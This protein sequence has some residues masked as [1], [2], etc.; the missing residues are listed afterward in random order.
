MAKVRVKIPKVV[1]RIAICT[2]LLVW[3]FHQIFVGEGRLAWER[4]GL[5]W[6]SLSR[7]EQCRIAW[8]RGPA[9]LWRVVAGVRPHPAISSLVFMGAT[10][11]IGALR[12][13]LVMSVQGLTLPFSRVAEICLVSHFFNSFLLGSTGGDLMKAYY[14]ARET[15]HLK[16]EAIAT[17]F[18]DRFLGLLSML[19]F[20]SI[21]MLPNLNLMESHRRL[22][23]LAGFTL[24]MLAAGLVIAVIAFRGGV[25]ARWPQARAWLKRL[26]RGETIERSLDACRRFG[27]DGRRL[28]HATALSMLLNLACVLQIWTLSQSLGLPLSMLSLCV[29]VPVVITISAVP[30]TP[31]GLGVRENLYVWLLAVPG[32]GVAAKQAL[33]LSLLAYGGSLLWSLLGGIVYVTYKERHHL[34]DLVGEQSA[35]RS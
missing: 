1:W 26:P 32:L 11:F 8:T 30:L 35:V 15:H 27:H 12:W 34:R 10:I 9:E 4:D 19:G 13:R 14:V 29:I 6:E 2:V 7:T 28:V 3:V 22:K 20:A 31:S 5:S 16:T 17:V 25:S 23:A 33:S 24:A 21:M 18:I